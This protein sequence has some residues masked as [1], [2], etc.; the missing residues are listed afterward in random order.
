MRYSEL[1]AFQVISRMG[2]IRLG[3]FH[4]RI[5]GQVP[6]SESPMLVS[7]N[8]FFLWFICIL[9]MFQAWFYLLLTILFILYI[10]EAVSKQTPKFQY[11][12]TVGLLWFCL[13]LCNLVN[14]HNFSLLIFLYWSTFFRWI[15]GSFFRSW[16]WAPLSCIFLIV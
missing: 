3:S 5:P 13:L 6:S 14:Y 2:L 4:K 11:K 9:H 15:T 12:I 16:Q 10:K 1:G 7:C 8:I